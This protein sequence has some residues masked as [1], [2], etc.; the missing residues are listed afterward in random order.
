MALILLRHTTPMVAPGTCYG[1][2]DLDV[3]ATFETEAATILA[4]LPP[5]RRPAHRIVTSPLIRCR[6]LGDFI[7]GQLG[8]SVD[9]DA[10]LKEMDFGTW[11]GR[12]WAAIPKTQIDAWAEDFFHAR[13]HGA[14]SVS[15]LSTRV[16]E[17]LADWRA[18]DTPTLIVT[19][20]G[21]I[22]AALAT[23]ETA[24]DFNAQ[25]DFGAFVTISSLQG[26][27]HE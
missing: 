15:M 11:E 12:P 22:R 18:S 26:N 16:H 27:P 1:Q 23:G 13:P 8:L 3:A 10:R 6:K 7:G 4:K 20:A 14:E 25:I 21:V 2:T 17:A 24:D 5:L 19:H 9:E